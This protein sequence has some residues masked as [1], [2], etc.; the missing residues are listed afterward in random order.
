MRGIQAITAVSITHFTEVKDYV[1]Q[2]HVSSR[3]VCKKPLTVFKEES[4]SKVM[5][6]RSQ[7]HAQGAYK[8]KADLSS[9]ERTLGTFKIDLQIKCKMCY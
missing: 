8:E 2:Q 9:P 3:A 1:Q 5:T 4:T 6:F 7:F